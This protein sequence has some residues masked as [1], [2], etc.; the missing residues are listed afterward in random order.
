MGGLG[1]DPADVRRSSGLSV[2]EAADPPRAAAAAVEEAWRT[3]APR[4]L[5]ALLRITRSMDRA[6]DLAQEALAQ[7]LVAWPR[8]GVPER[9]GAWLMT[10]AKRRAIDQFRAG[11]RRLR[12][13][14]EVAAGLSEA[15]EAE[16]DEALSADRVEDDV[17]RLMFTCCHPALTPDTRTVLTLRMVAGLSTREIARAYL[18]TEATVATRISRAKRTL[19]DSDTPLQEPDAPGRADRLASVRAAIYLLF[20]EGYAATGGADWT[21]P[22]LCAEAVRVARLLAA[23]TPGDPEAAGLL[24]L[25][26]LQSSR[27]PARIDASG[28]PVLLADQV[29]ARWDSDAI[30]RG[31]GALG[32]A[33]DQLGTAEAGPYLI[34]AAIAAEHARAA[35]IEA[36]DW[37]RIAAL[38]ARLAVVTD[39]VVVELNR[40]VALGRAHG[41]LAGLALTDE[42][43][44][45]G[46][47][48]SYHLLP[49]VRGDLLEQLGRREEAAAEF[50][51]AADLAGNDQERALLRDRAER[52]AGARPGNPGQ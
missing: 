35:S 33:R 28:S 27:L 45:G 10:T 25:L 20:N 24:A 4:L 39:S 8:D 12:A 38:Y 49:A 19:A 9:P 51:R 40:A 31:L 3:E 21:R 30:G 16:F 15:Y 1:R 22:D 11:E 37:A 42:L 50:R 17:L 29:R 36:T 2:P 6:E 47:L 34:Q 48:A 18:T 13:Y 41:P 14:T 43:V 7:A 23:L 5:G 46:R 44:S 26:E 32:S 52:A